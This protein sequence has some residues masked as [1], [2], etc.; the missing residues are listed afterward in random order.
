[1]FAYLF[2]VD[3]F[4][5]LTLK[6]KNQSIESGD[7]DGVLPSP[8]PFEWMTSQYGQSYQFLDILGLLDRVD[9]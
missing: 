7:I 3:N 6:G 5:H 2:D 8:I 9:A 4:Q 1:M